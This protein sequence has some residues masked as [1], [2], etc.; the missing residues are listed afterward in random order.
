MTSDNI[1]TPL[2]VSLK[3]MQQQFAR[4]GRI[5][6]NMTDR[7]ERLEDRDTNTN[8]EESG[9]EDDA[10]SRHKNERHG[11]GRRR[12]HTNEVDGDLR[13]IKL[14][15]PTFQGRSD[16]EAYLEWEKK[17]EL[18]FECHNYSEEKK[19][20]LAAIEFTDYAIVW[21]DQLM[22]NSRRYGERPIAT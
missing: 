3:A 5:M 11:N 7:L 10:S 6:E 12:G 1:E 8:N 22:I 19:V 17:V 16:P 4:F 15:I 9:G 18:I 13:S 2:E 14:K 21:W 20:R